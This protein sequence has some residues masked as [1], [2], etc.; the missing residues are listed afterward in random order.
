M[1]SSTACNGA[2]HTHIRYEE[3]D[4][5]VYSVMLV[6]SHLHLNIAHVGKRRRP[7]AE[8]GNA[9]QTEHDGA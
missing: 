9:I 2:A 1:H 5:L 3:G 7:A 4:H 6:I 8:N